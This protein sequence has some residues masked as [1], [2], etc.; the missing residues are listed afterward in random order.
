[1]ALQTINVLNTD[2]FAK[3][4]IK[5][6]QLAVPDASTTFTDDTDGTVSSC[7]LAGSGIVEID[8]E[9]ETAKLTVSA[10][11][12]K[13]LMLYTVSIECYIPK[14][15]GSHFKALTNMR[16][17]MMVARCTMWDGIDF[18]VGYDFTLG[19]ALGT[20][21]ITN[22]GLVLES[23]EADSAAELSGQNGVTLKLTSVQGEPPYEA[24]F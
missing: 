9:K 5:T 12:D 22:F 19:K 6:L 24:A 1:M 14:C 23:I 16:G 4:G 21:D 3:G 11:Q 13:G 17:E 20:T 15:S 8:F 7:T 18:M 10:S 2:H